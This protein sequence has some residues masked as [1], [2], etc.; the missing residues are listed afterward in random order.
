MKTIEAEREESLCNHWI[1]G[2]S[3][4]KAA[5]FGVFAQRLLELLLLNTLSG[6]AESTP[7]LLLALREI[8]AASLLA[9]D[10]E[11]HVG[12][13]ERMEWLADLADL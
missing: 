11:N 6:S 8:L 4:D 12:A 10:E 2:R 3:T 7:N 13:L 5:N 1:Q 9:L